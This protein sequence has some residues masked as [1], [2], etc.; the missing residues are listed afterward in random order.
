MKRILNRH[1]LNRRWLFCTRLLSL[2]LSWLSQKNLIFSFEIKIDVWINMIRIWFTDDV[3]WIEI[4]VR[5]WIK[6]VHLNNSFFRFRTIYCNMILFMTIKTSVF[7]NIFLFTIVDNMMKKNEKLRR[8]SRSRKK[9]DE[10]FWYMRTDCF[11]DLLNLFFYEFFA[12]FY[13][14]CLHKWNMF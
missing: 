4:I 2:L 8:I 7:V 3:H 13:N 1:W 6:I 9:W 10:S 5:H 11:V 14:D 12:S